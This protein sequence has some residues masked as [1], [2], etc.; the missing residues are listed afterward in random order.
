[1]PAMRL[2]RVNFTAWRTRC[3][4]VGSVLR[5]IRQGCRTIGR[6]PVLASVV[7]LSLGAGIGVNTTV[8]SWIQTFVFNPLPG[9]QKSGS[10][11]FIEPTT[12]T[13]AYP[14]SSWLEFR[15][16]R[17]RITSFQ[18][19]S[20]AR[21]VPLYVGAPGRTERAY[22]QLV[23]GNFFD[24][25]NLTPAAGRLL[26]MADAARPGGDPV[27]VISHDYWRSH[28]SGAD[29][30]IGSTLRVNDATVTV[31]GIAPREF[32]GSLLGL[33]FD[34]WMPATMATVLVPGSTELDDRGQRG[35]AVMGRLGD[36]VSREQA[37]QD[38]R[39]AMAALATGFP[40]TNQRITADVLKFFD[41]PRGPQRFFASALWF[42]QVVM[43]LL[44]LTVCGNTA[45]LVLARAMS[46]QKEAGVRL[47][48]GARPV[49]LVRLIL[50]EN[51][52]LALGGAL[53][54]VLIAIWGTEALRAVPMTGAF[55]IKF[56]TGIDLGTLA[57]AA[58]L[59][60][61]CGILF[62]T[63]AAA[64]LAGLEPL[65]ALGVSPQMSSRSSLRS[66]LMGAQLAMA[67]IV[68][69]AAA[70]FY[71]SFRETQWI[72][73]G[74]RTE[75]VL[76]AA[77]DLS[78][79][80][81]ATAGPDETARNDAARTFVSRLVAR[82]RDVPAVE[83]AAVSLSVP[84]DIH[85]LSRR[86]FRVEGTARAD[87]QLD[88][89]LQNVVTP[90]YF[91]A[92]NI[93]I[94]HGADFVS[95]EDQSAARQVIVNDAFVSQYLGEGP[96]LGRVIESR[97]RKYTIA[98]VVATTTYDAFGEPPTPIM[99]FSYRDRTYWN[100]EV[101]LRSRPGMENALAEAVRTAVLSLDPELPIYNVRTMTEHIDR[102]LV[103][104]KIPA[105][106]FVVLGPLMLLLAAIGVY[107]VVAYT[108]S[109]R[110]TE[111]G[112]R[113]ALGATR[114]RVTYETAIDSFRVAVN[115]VVAGAFVVI[116]V[117]LHLIR[118]GAKDLPAIIGVPVVLLIVCAAACWLPARKAASMSPLAALRK[119]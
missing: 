3:T 104:R 46:R 65:A 34:M 93:P 22:G 109:Q 98:G 12:D 37:Q 63:P 30:A 49:A 75:G 88:E 26:Q 14:G 57:F 53:V 68:L 66:L 44:L 73:P 47:A 2:H 32:Q 118:G 117:D 76:L 115:G 15:D 116:L 87:G 45:N 99:Y 69:A 60:L 80:L 56:Q 24:A 85:G 62:G 108:V 114:A 59:A 67:V 119:D 13:G 4:A 51:L 89:A 72:D 11:Y 16:F 92:L 20:A 40:K 71:Q 8:F 82:L 23:S 58:V 78:G 52:L 77:Y 102:N 41:A 97:D 79:R 35:Y 105:R 96:V 18:D 74:F 113:L 90:G 81:E 86:T 9:V 43:L 112:V 110:T 83:A 91:D 28:F 36:G 70:L 103:L 107:A 6:M 48:L 21:M 100:G 31:V 39:A 17:E 106:M 61:V 5:D 42:L 38:V 54:G 7:V 29:S 27:V 84:L 64:Q 101:H 1:M 94:R 19:L 55:P 33:S 50:T 95:L 111:I 25:L 10:L